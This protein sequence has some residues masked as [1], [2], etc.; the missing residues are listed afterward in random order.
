MLARLLTLPGSW[1]CWKR[2]SHL[3]NARLWRAKSCQEGPKTATQRGLR[4][5]GLSGPP[6]DDRLFRRRLVGEVLSL[7]DR[8]IQHRVALSRWRSWSGWRMGSRSAS[9]GR[10]KSVRLVKSSSGFDA[11]HRL[12]HHYLDTPPSIR[13]QCVSQHRQSPLRLERTPTGVEQRF[14]PLTI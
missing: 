4:G 11:S 3:P 1:I 8:C 7:F 2:C 9:L 12:H 10:C 5:P 13:P 14:V 6:L